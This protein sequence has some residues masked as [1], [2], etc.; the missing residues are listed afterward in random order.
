M[1][2]VEKYTLAGRLLLISTLMVFVGSTVAYVWSGFF[3]S[4]T[5]LFPFWFFF[6][7]GLVVALAW[8]F[9]GIALFTILKIRIEKDKEDS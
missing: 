2:P 4:F 9:L 7:P 5:G 3:D 1:N 8:F 6:I